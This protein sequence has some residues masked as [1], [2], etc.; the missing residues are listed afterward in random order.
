[1]SADKMFWTSKKQN[2]HPVFREVSN[3]ITKLLPISRSSLVV[4]SLSLSSF[5]VVQLRL[6]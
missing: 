1:M 5:C 3:D 6:R 4:K 2:E